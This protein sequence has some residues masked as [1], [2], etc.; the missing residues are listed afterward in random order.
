MPSHVIYG[1]FRRELDSHVITGSP[2]TN[3]GAGGAS[4]T[5]TNTSSTGDRVR[6]CKGDDCQGLGERGERERD[7]SFLERPSA[8]TPAKEGVAWKGMGGGFLNKNI[9]M[10]NCCVALMSNSP[11]SLGDP[12]LLMPR[13]LHCSTSYRRPPHITPRLSRCS[14]CPDKRQ[15]VTSLE[16]SKSP[17][18]QSLGKQAQSTISSFLPS[19]RRPHRHSMRRGRQR[20]NRYRA[21]EDPL[22]KVRD[23]CPGAHVDEQGRKTGPPAYVCG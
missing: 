12:K 6:R 21:E 3:R 18:M 8:L 10:N 16:I 17:T 15:S 11:H 9:V 5:T 2:S 19:T 22:A 1:G 4:T 13:S 20:W 7:V 14:P 23:V